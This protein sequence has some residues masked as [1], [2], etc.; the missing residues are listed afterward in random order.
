MRSV[1]VQ[2]ARNLRLPVLV[3]GLTCEQCGYPGAR[4]CNCYTLEQEA[5]RKNRDKQIAYIVRVISRADFVF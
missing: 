2:Y 4:T 1:A 5:L 3:Q